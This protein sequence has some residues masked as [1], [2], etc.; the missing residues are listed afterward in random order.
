MDN[1]Y[2]RKQLGQLVDLTEKSAEKQLSFFQH[3]LL[4]SSSTFGI[5][6]SLHSNSSSCLYI[7]LVFSLATVI[8]SLGCLTTAIV[9]YDHSFFVER[10]RQLFRTEVQSAMKEDR[11]V[12]GV[13]VEKKKRTK[14]CEKASYI[15]LCLSLILLS[16]YAVLLAFV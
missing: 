8:L 6:I 3:I 5:L 14:F 2:Y 10:S 4:V 11:E 9:V 12:A 13:V 15:L 1:D 16:C 7:R